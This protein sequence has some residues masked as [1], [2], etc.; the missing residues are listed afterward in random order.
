MESLDTVNKSLPE[1]LAIVVESRVE[2]QNRPMNA[3]VVE[4]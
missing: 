2:I 3:T 4:Y 1:I